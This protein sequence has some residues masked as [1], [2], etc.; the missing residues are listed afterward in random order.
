[1]YRNCC[2]RVLYLHFK[3]V[4]VHDCETVT[5]IRKLYYQIKNINLLV[6]VEFFNLI[7]LYNYFNFIINFEYCHKKKKI[8]FNITSDFIEH[9]ERILLIVKIDFEID[10]KFCLQHF[11][12][13]TQA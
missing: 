8:H 9:F 5:V 7:S 4:I 10:F 6:I 2:L 3:R 12:H 11:G 13:I 1:M